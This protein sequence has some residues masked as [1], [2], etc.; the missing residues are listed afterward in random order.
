MD[1]TTVYRVMHPKTQCGPW[2]PHN[3]AYCYL[4]E[5]EKNVINHARELTFRMS[6]G[7]DNVRS[8]PVVSSDIRGW[9]DRY[10]C[11]AL[12]LEWLEHWFTDSD[13]INALFDAG[14]TIMKFVLPAESVLH[15]KSGTQ[16]GFD[17]CDVLECED[18]TLLP[19]AC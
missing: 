2:N 16:C 1:T 7:W 11:A 13:T 5:E 14:Y 15:S 9:S 18:L 4:T 17:P 6:G 10:V 3:D 8:H 12:S 19:L